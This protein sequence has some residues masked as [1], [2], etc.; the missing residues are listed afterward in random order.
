MKFDS[1]VEPYDRQFV[2]WMTKEKVLIEN[3]NY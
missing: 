1:D 3:N 2:K